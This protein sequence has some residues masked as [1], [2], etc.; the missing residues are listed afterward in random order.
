MKAET[1]PPF[2]SQRSSKLQVFLVFICLCD[3]GRV[4]LML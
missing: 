1:G 2:L 3:M 4:L